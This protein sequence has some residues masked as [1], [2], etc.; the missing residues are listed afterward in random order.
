MNQAVSA[1]LDAPVQPA[2]TS[3]QEKLRET[4]SVE[5]P[6]LVP[7]QAEAPK[8]DAAKVEASKVEAP[9]VEAPK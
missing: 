3:W 2:P 1:A 5:A 4:A 8:V 7:A 6:D 9:K